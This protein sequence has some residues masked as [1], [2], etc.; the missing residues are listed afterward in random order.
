MFRNDIILVAPAAVPLHL[1][2]GVPDPDELDFGS[3]VVYL[4]RQEGRF[5][6]K[7]I[8]EE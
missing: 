5:E 1:T 7:I 8:D 4:M 6:N 3:S 2:P